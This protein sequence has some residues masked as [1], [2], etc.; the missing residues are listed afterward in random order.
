[1]NQQGNLLAIDTSTASMSVAVMRGTELLS[2]IT[3][4]A[5]RDHSLH[6]LPH[7]QELLQGLGFTP[8]EVDA[9]AVGIGPGSYT[10]VRI[11]VTVAK[12]LAW[13][14]RRPVIGVSS[15]EALALGSVRK[16]E[17]RTR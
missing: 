5:E 11:G 13:T 2:G 12:T 10:G 3:S 6:F 8:N 15:L 1:M 14:L 16:S 7:I 4:H 9:Y 17:S